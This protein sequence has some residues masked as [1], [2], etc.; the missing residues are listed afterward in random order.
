MRLSIIILIVGFWVQDAFCMNLSAPSTDQVEM[1]NR[2]TS[3]VRE[4]N[5]KSQRLIEE[6]KLDSASA[7]IDEALSLAEFLN[8]I[9]GETFAILNLASYYDTKGLPDSL[10][11]SVA[12]LLDRYE[13]T[14][15]YTRIGNLVAT[16]HHE[17]GN[18]QQSLDLYK[19]ML[20]AAKQDNDIRMQMGITQNMGN[21][22]SSLGDMP[23]AIDS[24]LS[25]L[26]MAEE[27]DDTLVT[28]VVLDNLASVNVDQENYELAE[29]YLFR[30]LELNKEIDNLRNQITNHIS[31]GVLYKE[32]D[33]YDLARQN[34]ER[35]LE[36]ADQ[37]GNVLSKIQAI[38][39]LGVLYT[40][41][42]DTDRALESYQESLRLSQENN[43]PIGFF[44]NHAGMG[45]LYVELEDYDRAI[46]NYQQA[47]EI[48]EK[49]Q[50]TDM[51]KTGLL[52][53]Y[54]TAE[55][56][57]D[58][59][60]AFTY[61]KRYSALTDSLAQTE[62]EDALARQEAMLQLRSER[63]R[64]E[65]LE[66]TVATQR[67]NTIMISVLGGVMLIASIWLVVLYRKK[68]NANDL[69][70]NKTK[71]LE[72]ANNVK[73]KLLSV[74]AHDLRTPISNIQGVV[75]MIRENMLDTEDIDTALNH[76]DFQLQQGI[77]T[78]TNYLEWAQDHRGGISADMEDIRLLEIVNT[79][80]HE[81]KKS[82]ENK[83]VEINN[84]VNPQISALADK[85]MMNVILRNLLSN[86]IKYV[87]TGDIITVN[88]N[89]TNNTV[90]LSVK[91]TGK[92]IPDNKL[93]NL[94]KPFNR[95]TRG[96]KGEIGTGLGL[97]LCKEFIEKQ[98]G[99]IRCESEVGKGTTFTVVL[100]KSETAEGPEQVAE[101]SGAK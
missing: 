27:R 11:T 20:D 76:I 82:A 41:T 73:D 3:Y 34:Y 43:I 86:A 40:E 46:E 42:G 36:I 63:E 47:L 71:E 12:P 90:E 95:V 39:N 87:D 61:L 91:D 5:E 67:S 30:A 37:I 26:E 17:V 65:L 22:Y 15:K 54:E 21:S 98:G 33:K 99:S 28:A 85:H 84:M 9:E 83:N 29:E 13:G 18:F 57:G 51:V 93:K 68:K 77:N 89:E 92:G 24:Y 88:T 10:L 7:V 75:Y 32:W 49:V 58:T 72:E 101:K 8:D 6:G 79:A 100:Q 70:K 62:R 97:S 16:S 52:N 96:T 94:F 53:L 66:E 44:Y 48:A 35:V 74:L 19:K 78:L 81:I 56:S 50:A 60:L 64:S 2:D 4:L 45:D 69:L 14:E 23:S 80:I 1:T 38:Y 59:A 31:L 25:S 55:E